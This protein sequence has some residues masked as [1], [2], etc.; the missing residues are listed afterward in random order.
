MD[1]DQPPIGQAAAEGLRRASAH[2][3]RAGFELLRGAAAFLEE[4]G[5]AVRGADDEEEASAG[6]ERIPVE[7]DGDEV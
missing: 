7:D 3:A 5:R 6:A 1:D 2:F 4:L